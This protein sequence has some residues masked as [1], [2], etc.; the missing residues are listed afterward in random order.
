MGSSDAG[1]G[2]DAMASGP[3]IGFLYGMQIDRPRGGGTIHGY[4]LAKHL[5]ALGARLSSWYFD[6]GETPLVHGYR[7]RELL[8]F[9]RE[10]D[11]L[12]LRIEW[13]NVSSTLSW[14]K[15]LR[16]GT[17]PVIWELNGTPDELQF[18]ESDEVIARVVSRLRRNA[19]A[20]DAAIGVSEEVVDFA[21]RKLRI[22]DVR[23]IPNGS[24]PDLFVPRAEPRS[25]PL[26]CAWI[27]T[28]QAGWHDLGLLYELAGALVHAGSDIEFHL[29]GNPK[30]LPAHPP[31]NVVARGEFR[32]E[33]LPR[34][35]ARCDVGIHF[36]RKSDPARP[37]VGSPLKLFDYMACGMPVIVNA[38]G[39]QARIIEETGCG[40]FAEASVDGMVRQLMDIA[41][42]PEDVAS[43]GQR[44]RAAV[45]SRYNWR[46]NAEETLAVIRSLVEGGRRT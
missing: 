46:I 26:K 32:Y 4:Q 43:R 45:L 3:R 5:S 12:Y 11:C 23:C 38:P 28:S 10:I 36:F 24:D 16:L 15:A 39:Q 9:V 13:S 31:K 30:G 2:F 44:A 6:P 40:W 41:A 19:R 1:A 35:L 18:S 33:D 27:G 37:V 42:R 29:F 20:C 34:E 8:R 21:R 22:D 17:L 14:L 7:G 25:G